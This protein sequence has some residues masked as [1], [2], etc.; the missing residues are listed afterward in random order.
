MRGGQNLS[1]FFM[2]YIYKITNPDGKIYVGQ[3]VSFRKRLVG[4]AKYAT[5]NAP[6][7]ILVES[8][9]KHGFENHVFQL[10]EMNVPIEKAAERESYWIKYFNSLM[11]CNPKGMN[12]KLFDKTVLHRASKGVNEKEYYNGLEDWDLKP[13]TGAEFIQKSIELKKK[14]TAIVNKRTNRTFPEWSNKILAEKLKKPILCYDTNGDFIKEFDSTK[15]AVEE[16][17]IKR[18][19]IKDSLR[20][21][22]WS[23]GTYMFKY[24]EENYPKKIDVDKVTFQGVKKPVLL[25]NSDYAIIKE[26]SCPQEAADAVGISNPSVRNFCYTKGASLS[27]KGY[28]FVYKEDYDSLKPSEMGGGDNALNL[29]P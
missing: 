8:I 4:Y 2:A 27:K 21:G 16:L 14:L 26:Y 13:F 29:K 19:S 11:S 10:L 7:S 15:S 23:R 28:R 3:T 5:N 12:T 25:L 17:N 20:K 6:Q 22:S 1:A 24:W 18:S 9:R